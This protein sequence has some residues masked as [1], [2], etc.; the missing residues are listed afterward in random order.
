MNH[1][2]YIMVETSGFTRLL[3]N[4]HS[5][6]EALQIFFLKRQSVMELLNSAILTE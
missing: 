1:V 6:L 4:N 3:F 2:D 5:V